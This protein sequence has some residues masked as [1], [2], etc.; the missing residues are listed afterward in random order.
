MARIDWSRD[1]GEEHREDRRWAVDESRDLAPPSQS[2]IGRGIR[3]IAKIR[4]QMKTL[5]ARFHRDRWPVV[6]AKGRCRQPVPIKQIAPR[7]VAPCIADRNRYRH[8]RARYYDRGSIDH[9]VGPVEVPV[10]S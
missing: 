10:R 6:R 1:S 8:F 5:S 7:A 3:Q 2:D 9:G 4:G